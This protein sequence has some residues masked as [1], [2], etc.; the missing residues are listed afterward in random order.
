M[1]GRLQV[2]GGIYLSKNQQ[3]TY[4]IVEDFRRGDLS[5]KKAAEILGVSEKTI[6][7]I[8]KRIREQGLAG[9]QH[10]N[11]GNTP[12]NKISSDLSTEVVNLVRDHYFDFNLTHAKEMIEARHD[13]K[14]SYTTFYKWCRKAGVGASKRRRSSKSRIYRERLANEGLMLQMD[15]SHHE[16]FGGKKCCLIA[17]IDDATSDIPYA[18]FFDSETTWA[19]LKVL[20]KVV[21][22]KGIPYAIYTDRAGWA[23]QK[24]E[25]FSYFKRVCE[26]LGIT[27]ITT[28]SP[29]A[30]GRIENAWKTMQSRLIPEMRLHKIKSMKDANRYILQNF[31]PLYWA[32]RNAVIPKAAQYRYRKLPDYLNLD[33]IFSMQLTRVV[34]ADQT[35]T[36][37]GERYK[38]VEKQFGHLKGKQIKILQHETGELKFK[39]G[40]I[41]LKAEKVKP[42]R[43]RWLKNA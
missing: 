1:L 36:Y 33:E 28:S 17:M 14:L 32:K 24:R 34:N 42:P 15:G 21:E 2:S 3:F 7:R 8:A 22:I 12:K 6:Q 18:E 5:R 38:L 40:H 41:T 29:Q 43:R 30:K 37:L 39:L 27:L 13:I 31:I 26:D 23:G 16:W 20:R 35:V 9:M 25:Y 4:A 11:T 10:G 19:C